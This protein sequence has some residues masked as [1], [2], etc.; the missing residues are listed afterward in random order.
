MRKHTATENADPLRALNRAGTGLTYP[1]NFT[2]TTL[3]RGGPVAGSLQRFRQALCRF[4]HEASANCPGE[5]SVGVLGSSY[6]SPPTILGESLSQLLP[7]PPAQFHSLSV[8][9]DS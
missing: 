5:R 9:F 8:D 7:A 1:E 6:A 3:F 2:N 4:P